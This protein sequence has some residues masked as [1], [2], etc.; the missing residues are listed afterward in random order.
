VEITHRRGACSA[1]VAVLTAIL[2]L[3]A[4]RN[5]QGPATTAVDAGLTAATNPA[6]QVR[7]PPPVWH[8][9]VVKKPPLGRQIEAAQIVIASQRTTAE[10]APPRA[11]KRT[12]DEAMEL[13]GKLA[14][15]ARNGA[16]FAALAVKY[17]DWPQADRKL[18][19]GY[20][21]YLGVLTEG[22]SEILP[23]AFKAALALKPGEVS[24]PVGSQFGFH[25]F[26]RLPARRVSAIVL[27]HEGTGTLHAPR[28]KA[29]AL[30]LAQKIET[31][32]AAG[33]SF[34][35]EAF[36]SSDDMLSA[37]R[38]GDMGVLGSTSRVMPQ[39]K[40]IAGR[41]NVGQVSAPIETPSGIVIVKRTE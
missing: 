4:C 25:V 9:E 27:T 12:L 19:P 36:E 41:L 39:L 6:A 31:E 32:L 8:R 23:E 5:C 20:G 15:Q 18:S 1:R 16:D 26:K 37:G 30:Q 40:E 22:G 35:D 34:G 10:W 28:T 21:G 29:E 7:P 33:K 14:V 17:S 3:S 24:Q 13:A 38:E 2:G 11:R